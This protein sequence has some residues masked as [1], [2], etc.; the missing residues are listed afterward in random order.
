MS[1]TTFIVSNVNDNG[2]GSLR[3]AIL[4]ANAAPGEDLIQITAVGVLI[5]LSPL[6]EI[7]EAVT[8]EGPGAGLLAIDGGNNWRLLDVA[9]VPVTITAL[10][11]QNGQPATDAGG[12]LRSLGVLSLRQVHVLSNTSPTGGGGVYVAGPVSIEGGLFASNYSAGGVGGGLWATGPAV[13]SGATFANNRANGQGGGA[14]LSGG[15]QVS[16]GRFEQNRSLASNG[17]GLYAT[18]GTTLTNMQFHNNIAQTDG[19]GRSRL[20]WRVYR[21]CRKHSFCR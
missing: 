5:L 2:P 20:S 16:H 21:L 15:S 12:G 11:L 6:P 3:Q 4:H 7:S 1:A 18:G 9:A 13:I 14:H 19:G 8:I 17:G 10:T